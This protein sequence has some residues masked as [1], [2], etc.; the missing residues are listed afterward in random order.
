MQEWVICVFS[1]ISCWCLVTRHLR[2]TLMCDRDRAQM[3]VMS[4]LTESADPLMNK[5]CLPATEHLTCLQFA[6][7][8]V[9]QYQVCN[10]RTKPSSAKVRRLFSSESVQIHDDSNIVSEWTQSHLIIYKR[11]VN[12]TCPVSSVN[13]ECDMWLFDLTYQY[14]L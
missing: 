7:E 10:D 8:T 5:L 4:Y 12:R 6:H 13:L 1:W 3:W 9:G 14:V 11:W 2:Q